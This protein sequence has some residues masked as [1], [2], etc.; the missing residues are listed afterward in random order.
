MFWTAPLYSLLLSIIGNVCVPDIR[1]QLVEAASMTSPD[2]SIPQK[3]KSS[4]LPVRY[5]IVFAARSGAQY[6]Q[7]M[8]TLQRE[9]V[10]QCRQVLEC[11]HLLH[12]AKS[13]PCRFS[14]TS[15]CS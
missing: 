2:R 10:S 11:R 13:R 15:F 9:F 14:C 12:Q 8:D 3:R 1:C 4:S 7:V 6:F 5:S